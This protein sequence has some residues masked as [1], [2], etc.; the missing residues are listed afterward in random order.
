MQ[1]LSAGLTGRAAK[2]M[3]EQEAPGLPCAVRTGHHVS[4]RQ[5]AR[6]GRCSLPGRVPADWALEHG[7][8]RQK[9]LYLWSLGAGLAA[10]RR[11]VRLAA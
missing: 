3:E 6:T 1:T 9:C 5:L 8:G 7:F 11:A 10:G 2:L 4:P